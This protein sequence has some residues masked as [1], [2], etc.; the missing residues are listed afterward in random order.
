M[1]H[2]TRR[3][4]SCLGVACLTRAII[5]RQRQW[6]IFIWWSGHWNLRALQC[7]HTYAV[8]VIIG[9]QEEEGDPLIAPVQTL[10][11]DG[12]FTKT[13]KKSDII[14]SAHRPQIGITIIPQPRS[15]KMVQGIWQRFFIEPVGVHHSSAAG[16]LKIA[17]CFKL[18]FM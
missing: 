7:Q 4:L 16:N 3:Q 17:L 6:R 9:A 14:T 1:S 18:I 2:H 10:L 8:T 15:H 12:G 13:I 11:L 5:W